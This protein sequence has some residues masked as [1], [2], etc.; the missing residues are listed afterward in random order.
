MDFSNAFQPLILPFL[1][2]CHF[3]KS[4]KKPYATRIYR[5]FYRVFNW[6]W[7]TS[8]IKSTVPFGTVLFLRYGRY[9]DST[10]LQALLES[11]AP[12]PRRC[13]ELVHQHQVRCYERSEVIL[14]SDHKETIILIRKIS[15]L[16]LFSLPK[17]G[18]PFF[19]GFTPKIEACQDGFR[20]CKPFLFLA[21]NIIVHFIPI[22]F[23]LRGIVQFVIY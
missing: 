12:S 15:V 20:P 13:G 9:D 23:N 6:G 5:S 22:S 14:S 18:G 7:L 4:A 3:F 11:G 21:A 10:C 17:K 2:K 8:T 1:Q 19:I 16:W